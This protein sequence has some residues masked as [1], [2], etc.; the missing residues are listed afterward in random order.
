LA[1]IPSIAQATEHTVTFFIDN[2]DCC[3]SLE[4]RIGE[5]LELVYGV[6]DYTTDTGSQTVTVT[7]DDKLMS[8]E[9]LVAAFRKEGLNP[10]KP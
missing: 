2:M 7:Y 5:I 1:I 10:E 8:F 4:S 6:V 9:E 3:G